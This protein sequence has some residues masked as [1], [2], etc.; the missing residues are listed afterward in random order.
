MASSVS[1]LCG[2][3]E[4]HVYEKSKYIG[5]QQHDFWN[6]NILEYRYQKYSF[7]NQFVLEEKI[8]CNL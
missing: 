4:K 1:I 7:W 6:L 2:L 5:K 8:L 3:G